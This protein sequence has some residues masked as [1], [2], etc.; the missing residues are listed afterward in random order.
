MSTYNNYPDPIRLFFEI[1]D[2]D[3]EFTGKMLTALEEI[4]FESKNYIQSEYEFQF[5]GTKKIS[6]EYILQE[7]FHVSPEKIGEKQYLKIHLS[8]LMRMFE[9]MIEEYNS[10]KK[11]VADN[12]ISLPKAKEELI[13]IYYFFDD[14]MQLYSNHFSIFHRKSGSIASSRR[15]EAFSSFDTFILS[16]MIMSGRINYEYHSMNYVIPS[17]ISLIRSTIELILKNSLRINKIRKRD[18]ALLKISGFFFIDFYKINKE[19]IDFPVKLSALKKIYEWSNYF[20]HGG[21]TSYYWMIWE[22]QSL[23]RNFFPYSGKNS[24]IKVDINFMRDRDDLLKE[25]IASK[26]N[27]SIEEIDIEYHPRF[28]HLTLK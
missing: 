2:S 4:L 11:S 16:D 3:V 18:G 21:E 6:D 27:L 12:E 20:V 28:E 1:Y 22:A 9:E 19:R 5:P 13:P 24:T 25:F 14:F 8:S 17:S 26:L 15:M 23:L 7:I 10:V